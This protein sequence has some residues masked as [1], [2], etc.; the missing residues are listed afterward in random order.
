MVNEKWP[1]MPFGP[2]L[3]TDEM[4]WAWVYTA[5]KTFNNPKKLWSDYWMRYKTVVISLQGMDFYFK[6]VMAAARE[7]ETRDE[8]E[9]FLDANM[10]NVSKNS[11]TQSAQC[12]EPS[13]ES[14]AQIFYEGIL[15]DAGARGPPPANRVEVAVKDEDLENYPSLESQRSPLEFLRSN[16]DSIVER[17]HDFTY[18]RDIHE[19]VDEHD[20]QPACK[21][22]QILTRSSDGSFGNEINSPCKS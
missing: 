11:R 16:L 22:F 18:T 10:N 12:S 21:S 3:G 6:D 8:L 4:N 14:F 9:K 2:S 19:V 17:G 7:C 13:L 1:K 15:P 20:V 5:P